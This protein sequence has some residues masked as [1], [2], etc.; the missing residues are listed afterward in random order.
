MSFRRPAVDVVVPFRGSAEGLEEL[1]ARLMGLEL[2]PGD[3]VLIVDNSSRGKSRE[4][5]VPVIHAA[6]VGT[7]AYARNQGARRGSAE[8]LLFFDADVIPPSDLLDRYFVPPP[9]DET[10]ILAGGVVDEPVPPDGPPVARYGYLRKSMSQENTFSF[11]AWA[12]PQTANAAFRR[13]AFESV[14]CFREEIRAAEDADLFYRLKTAGWAVERREKAA[15]VHR[16]RSTVRGFV[17]QKLLHGAG[18]A[19]LD[20]TYPGS[21]PARRRPGLVWWGVRHA[22]RR[23]VTAARTR[24]RDEALWAVFEPLELISREFGRSLRNERRAR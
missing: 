20:E 18:G 21:F 13:V 9:S 19:W 5:T 4:G 16:N 11:G 10:A 15:V 1:R 22:C 6:D 24:D 12:F 3:T 8:W 23:L 14:G 17:T 7:P 2:R